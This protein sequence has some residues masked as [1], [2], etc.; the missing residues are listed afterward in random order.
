M[1]YFGEKRSLMFI[2]PFGTVLTYK[3]QEHIHNYTSYYSSFILCLP[4]I[5]VAPNSMLNLHGFFILLYLYP[6]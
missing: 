5:H 4:V 3:S 6:M 1:V 2:F